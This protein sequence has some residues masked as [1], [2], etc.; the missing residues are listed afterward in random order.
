MGGEHRIA[1]Q[2][3][4]FLCEESITPTARPLHRGAGSAWRL[5]RIQCTAQKQDFGGGVLVDGRER[6]GPL[7]LYRWGIAT[8][9]R[10]LAGEGAERPFPCLLH[11]LVERY[12]WITP[13]TPGGAIPSMAWPIK[14]GRKPEGTGLTPPPRRA[15]ARVWRVVQKVLSLSGQNHQYQHSGVAENGRKEEG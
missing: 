6:I 12:S 14:P 9:G 4:V 1:P 10:R 13:T 7:A 3:N 8:R 5:T 15:R 2:V 11:L